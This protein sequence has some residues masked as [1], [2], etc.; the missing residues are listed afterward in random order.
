MGRQ[1]LE[2]LFRRHPAPRN[3]AKFLA[4]AIR[5]HTAGAPDDDILITTIRHVGDDANVM[6]A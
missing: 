1:N 4:L 6:H 2:D 5:G 3:W